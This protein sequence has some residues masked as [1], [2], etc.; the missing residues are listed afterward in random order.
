MI[1]FDKSM[2]QLVN[3]IVSHITDGPAGAVIADAQGDAVTVAGVSASQLAGH[4]NV[5]HLP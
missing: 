4:P 2:F 5:F 3:A 1:Q